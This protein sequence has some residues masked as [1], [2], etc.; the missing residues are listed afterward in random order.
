LISLIL[1]AS[2]VALASS[3]AT[4]SKTMEDKAAFSAL[5]ERALMAMLDGRSNGTITFASATVSCNDGS[6][7]LSSPYFNASS[8]LSVRCDFRFPRV[9]GIH[10]LTFSFSMGTLGLKVD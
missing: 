9:D 8:V 2:S 4:F 10:E 5:N 1:A 7:F 6:L 3:Y